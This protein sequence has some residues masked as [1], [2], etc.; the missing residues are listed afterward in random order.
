MTVMPRR[1][2][3]LFI[4]LSLLLGPRAALAQGTQLW[5][6]NLNG[7]LL[8]FNQANSVAVDTD[9]NVLAA[10][11]TENAGT[12]FDFTVAKFAADGTRLWRR[13]LNGTFGLNDQ[14][15]SVA[16]DTDGNV[17][18]AGLTDNTGTGWDF[19]VAKF[20]PGGTLLWRRTLNGTANRDDVAESVAVDA[21]GNVLAAGY[22]L[23]TGTGQD[24]TVAKFAPDGTPLWQQ[25]FSGTANVDDAA[26]SV[27]VDTDGN[28]L[29][30]G[31]TRNTGSG[32]DF[33]VAKCAPDGTLLW[34]QTLNGTANGR[35]EAY[36]VAVGTDGNV[37]AAGFTENSF[38]GRDFTVARFA[39][40]GTP[41]WQQ[42]L[43]GTA[44]VDDAAVAVA[45]DTEG[46]V[47]AAGIT[48]NTGTGRDFTVVKFARDG[49]LWQQTINGT[50]NSADEAWSVAVDTQGNVLAAGYTVNTGTDQD[51]TVAKFAPDGTLFWQQSINGIDIGGDYALSV[52]ADT[53]GNVLAAGATRNRSDGWDFTVAKFAGVDDT[54]WTVCAPE[55]GVCAFTGTTAVRYGANGAFVFKTVTDGTV[56]TNA[57]FGD[58]IFGIVKECSIRSTPP[59]T[60]WTLCAPEGGVCAFTGTMKVRYGAN[61]SFVFKTLTDGTAC[62][63]AAF[64]DPIFGTV[65][66]C[67]IPSTP[68]WTFCAPEGG[69]C[70]F[71]GTQQVRYGANDTF[72]VRTLTGGTPC[73][74]QVFGDPIVGTVKHCDINATVS[75]SGVGPQAAITCPAGAFLIAPNHPGDFIPSIINSHPPGTTFCLQAGVHALNRS[76]TPRTGDTYVGE[77]GAI[78]DG[79]G[80]TTTDDTQAAFR[81]YDDPND[82]ND[83]S[84]DVDSVTIRNLV[85]RNMPQWGIHGFRLA[86]HWTI[87][88]NEIAS[89]RW[90]LLFG[91][92]F[93]IRNNYIH[94]NVG[95]NPS[96]PNPAERGGGY[97]GEHASN[98]TF[99]GNEI[100]YN[101]RE[102]KVGNASANVTFRN[103]F[104]HHNVGD[105]IWFDFN[106]TNALIEGNRVED[107]GRGGIAFEAS[108]GATI[109]NNTLRRNAADAVLISMSQ[110]AADLQQR[111]RS[112]RRRDPIF[113]QLRRAGRRV[114]SSE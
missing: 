87:E 7:T 23:N 71:S 90:G 65:K 33:T 84:A 10:G 74:N 103:N 108:N 61:G 75:P 100:A 78:L 64:G 113:P 43:N 80:W 76:I 97:L 114:R 35:D 16:V 59:V 48:E 32:S 111:A 83:P 101:G 34:R 20:A 69:V 15:L 105:G 104:V 89:N 26:S 25:T 55:G 9:G 60:N 86:D 5:Q 98:T 91:P 37:L 110:N 29:A 68:G 30:A 66:Q 112:E 24:F 102:Q 85:I 45:V 17:L 2:I 79:T 13:T 77:Y 56:C 14:A 47:F 53:Q 21:H 52:V 54:P 8:P 18:A 96:S 106:N 94:H 73:T 19:T 12:R 72:V 46:N 11:V 92:D 57:V 58:P 42:T 67:D 1:A 93:T 39:P 62:T 3:N 38:R 36:S 44:N 50:A 27:A 49:T 4:T 41:L 82:P 95:P 88:Y 22:T 40:G 70:A 28:V 107:N 63:N 6:Q 109:R 51:F 31:V 99:D 81:V